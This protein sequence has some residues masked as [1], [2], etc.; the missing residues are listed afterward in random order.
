MVFA[1]VWMILYQDTSA[2]AND[3]ICYALINA[4]DAALIDASFR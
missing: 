4:V 3:S 2:A 1:P